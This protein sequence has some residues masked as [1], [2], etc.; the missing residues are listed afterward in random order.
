MAKDTT[1]DMPAKSI[2]KSDSGGIHMKLYWEIDLYSINNF[3]GIINAK[4]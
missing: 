3:L 2:V 1:S 4:H